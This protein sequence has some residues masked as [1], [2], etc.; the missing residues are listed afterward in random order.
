M[1]YQRWRKHGTTEVTA[2]QLSSSER[3][4][5]VYGCDRSGKIVA[6]YCSMHYQR[7]QKYGTPGNAAPQIAARVPGKSCEV[8]GC[9]KRINARGFC[10]THYWRLMHNGHPLAVSV[11][12]WNYVERFW[13]KVIEGDVPRRLPSGGPCW[14]WNGHTTVNGYGIFTTQITSGKAFGHPAH[15]WAYEY[16][17]HE[18]PEGLELDHLC[19]VRNCVNP[20][21]LEPVP[22]VVNIRRAAAW[23]KAERARCAQGHLFSDENTYR[24]R[25]QR[26][27]RT[28]RRDARKR[29]KEKDAV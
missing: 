15:R 1:H 19:G 4:C 26:H 5:S 11:E 3:A 27:C 21:H 12:R 10:H 22:P 7:F 24:W 2:T 28:C 16:M 13:S 25:G 18:I 23:T 6:G 29:A 9:D 8:D 20:E 17:V 14:L